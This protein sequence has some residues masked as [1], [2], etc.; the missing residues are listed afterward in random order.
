LER[1]CVKV[2]DNSSESSFLEDSVKVLNFF[3]FF[4][5]IE[6]KIEKVSRVLSFE[7]FEMFIDEVFL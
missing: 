3:I 7:T 6:I 1:Q 4:I 5:N 2:F